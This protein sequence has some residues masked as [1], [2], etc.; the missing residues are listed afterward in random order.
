VIIISSSRDGDYI[1]EPAK[2]LGYKVARGSSTRG[3][4]KALKEMVSLAKNHSF[5][6]TPDGPKGPPFVVKEGALVLAYLTGLP[7]YALQVSVSK[8]YVFKS[9]DGFVLPLP[10]ARISVIYSE[11]IYVRSKEV[12]SEIKGEIEEFMG[13]S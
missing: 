6:I 9:W 3:G 8:A 10:F 1:A 12:F 11:A 5:G 2:L 4:N 13:K 7:I